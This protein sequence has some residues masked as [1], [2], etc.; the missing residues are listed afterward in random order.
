[1]IET[2]EPWAEPYV[3]ISG[4][5]ALDIGA[6]I[7][8]WAGFLSERFELVRAYEPNPAARQFFRQNGNV[9]LVP[10]AVA[11]RPGRLTLYTY[12]KLLDTSI[13]ERDEPH[14][15]IEVEAVTL[16]EIVDETVDFV[17]IDTEGSEFP[18][19]CGGRE[20][21][22]LHHPALLI[23]VHAHF[24]PAS[25]GRSCEHLL[26]DLGYQLERIPHPDRWANYYWL[27]AQ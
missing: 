6:N 4:N 9:E 5:T 18:I 13:V 12:E 8:R 11:E 15:P 16:D 14:V 17:K 22:A 27:A 21:L 25:A 20:A 7:G 19:L 26:L 10:A 1:M 24:A 3:P 23:E 2:G